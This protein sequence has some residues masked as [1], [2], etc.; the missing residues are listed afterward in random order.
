MPPELSRLKASVRYH[1]RSVWGLIW[2]VAHVIVLVSLC[3]YGSASLATAYGVGAIINVLY[4]I[5]DLLGYANFL[6]EQEMGL[7]DRLND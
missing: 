5:S 4:K 2:P 7:H 6:K 1:K 3:V